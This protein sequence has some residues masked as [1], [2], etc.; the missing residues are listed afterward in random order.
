MLKPLLQCMDDDSLSPLHLVTEALIKTL[1]STNRRQIVLV[2]SVAVF[3]IVEFSSHSLGFDEVPD[4]VQVPIVP[5]HEH[6]PHTYT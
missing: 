1:T 4:V 6:V 2:P 5:V 3:R